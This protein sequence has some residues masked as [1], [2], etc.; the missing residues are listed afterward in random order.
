M[1]PLP[2]SE[3]N[4][5]C[6]PNNAL[7]RQTL[8]KVEYVIS[9]LFILD[10]FS[11][12]NKSTNIYCYSL[13][14]NPEIP[15]DSRILIANLLRTSRKEIQNDIGIYFWIGMNIYSDRK[16]PG[17]LV[18]YSISEGKKFEIIVKFATFIDPS[19][20]N[21]TTTVPEEIIQFLNKQTKSIKRDM[22]LFEF[23][24]SQKYFNMN[25]R[26]HIPNLKLDVL[27]GF[28]T[29]FKLC[30]DGFRVLVNSCCKIIREE[31]V[32]STI[33]E[34]GNDKKGLKKE[35]IYRK[36]ITI[37]GR[38]NIYTLLGIDFEKTPL[39]TFD[40]NG[41]EISYLEYFHQNY[42]IKIKDPHQPLL[43]VESFRDKKIIHLVPELVKITGPPDTFNKYRQN[44][45]QVS[46]YTQLNPNQRMGSILDHNY[47]LNEY[48]KKN[49][50]KTVS[51][52]HLAE[53]SEIKAFRLTPPDIEQYQK[54]YISPNSS[55]L[56]KINSL[57][58]ILAFENWTFIYPKELYDDAGALLFALQKA[59]GAL[60]IKILDPVWCE[61]D[62]FSDFAKHLGSPKFINEKTQFVLVLFNEN[63]NLYHRFKCFCFGERPIPSQAVLVNSLDPKKIQ[64]VAA[65]IAKQI[66]AKLGNALWNVD[67]SPLKLP[68]KRIMVIGADVYHNTQDS[69]ESVIGICASF[70]ASF[71]KYYS[72]VKFQAKGKEVMDTISSLI[73]DCIKFYSTKNNNKMPEIIMFYRDGVGNSQFNWVTEIEIP[74]ILNGFAKVDPSY[75]P[76]FCEILVNKRLDERFFS[77]ADNYGKRSY[78]NPP[79]GTLISTQVVSKNRYDFY[80]CAQ[81]VT[82]GTCTP[83]HYTV[84]Y[85]TVHLPHDTLTGFTYYQCFNY[86][87][88]SGAVRVPACAQY[89][90]KVAYLA[91]ECVIRD[92][93]QSLRSR[94]SF[95]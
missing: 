75:K 36:V 58:E 57:K 66:N 23:G 3:I 48:I 60:G 80:L 50:G 46:K 8:G 92:L 64:S 70:N 77:Y 45:K 35:L 14:F 42:K 62:R 32:H 59:G 41:K 51:S 11:L 22:N 74:G 72:R 68:E 85:D 54:K 73:E 86:F 61:V 78:F 27:T 33:L 16:K 49:K 37:Y 84:V 1:E 4:I 87:N 95:L 26:K 5:P 76:Q 52:F 9:N 40:K 18:Y 20:I 44:L 55:G 30:E 19:N 34:Y 88:W 83:T 81:D 15:S 28:T 91:G 67:Y 65:N 89:A 69:K 56:F 2:N 53:D 43:Q 82:I 29:S 79:S 21:N 6:K 13:N 39:S 93:P 12:K 47:N 94:L 25:D 24:R 71:T 7:I 10:D 90:H 63:N 17:V 38:N 31:T